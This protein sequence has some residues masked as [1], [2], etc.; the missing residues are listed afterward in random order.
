MASSNTKKTQGKSTQKPKVST[1]IWFGIL[2]IVLFFVVYCIAFV[3]GKP[4]A[5]LD[6]YRN[7]QAQTTII[8]AKNEQGKDVPVEYLHGEQNRIW[9]SLDKIPKSLQD[10]F[11]CLEDKRFYDHHGVDWIRTIAAVVK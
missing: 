11:R 10:S 2:L 9:V 8:Y 1:Y 6:D 4:A 5:D 3:H 7:N